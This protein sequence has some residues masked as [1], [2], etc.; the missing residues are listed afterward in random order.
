MSSPIV[1]I[2]F[3]KIL[4]LIKTASK[5][6]SLCQF[7]RLEYETLIGSGI[8]NVIGI[9]KTKVVSHKLCKFKM[10]GSAFIVLH[11]MKR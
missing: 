7:C 5:V 9:Y 4:L 1:S 11:C 8:A 3:I 10:K 2:A 6:L